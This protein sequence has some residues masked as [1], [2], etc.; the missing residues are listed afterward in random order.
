VLKEFCIGSPEFFIRADVDQRDRPASWKFSDRT[1]WDRNFPTDREARLEVCVFLT[2]LPVVLE[3]H[4]GARDFASQ[5]PA[6]LAKALSHL[7]ITPL[8]SQAGD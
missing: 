4:A 2:M 5:F 8:H 6:E 3:A 1:L 7:G